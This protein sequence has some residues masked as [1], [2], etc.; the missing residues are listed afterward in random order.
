MIS[1]MYHYTVFNIMVV[2]LG[3]IIL[4]VHGQNNGRYSIHS[5]NIVPMDSRNTVRILEVIVDFLFACLIPCNP[6][7]LLILSFLPMKG[8]SNL[9]SPC[10]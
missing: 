7:D 8:L 3:C 2:S 4:R 1:Y 6:E 10:T 9:D 5:V